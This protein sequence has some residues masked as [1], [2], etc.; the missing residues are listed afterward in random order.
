[1]VD[2][3][4][5]ELSFINACDSCYVLAN[6]NDSQWFSYAC[7]RLHS[8]VWAKVIGY[9]YEPAKLLKLHDKVATVHFFGDHSISETQTKLCLRFSKE[10]PNKN[11]ISKVNVLRVS[12]FQF[13]HS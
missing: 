5:Q 2:Y 1:M 10:S 11:Y 6:T 12:D 4:R 9:P 8:L 3:C 7:E 13:L